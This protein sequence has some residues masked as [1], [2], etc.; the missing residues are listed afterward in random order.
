MLEEVDPGFIRQVAKFLSIDRSSLYK[1]R[2][3]KQKDDELAK[4][5]RTVLIEHK[6]YGHKRIALELK[7]GK[8]RARP[9]Q[10]GL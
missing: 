6:H 5:I 10:V 3:Q 2:L 8:H 7:I 1:I 9:C 4:Y